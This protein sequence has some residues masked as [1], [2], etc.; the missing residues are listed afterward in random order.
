MIVDKIKNLNHNK[1]SGPD[2]MHS[3]LLKHYAKAFA[4]PLTLIITASLTNNQ[5]PIQYR[6]ANVTP[7]FKKSDE[8]LPSN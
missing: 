8:T 4:I 5:L 1:A 2:N 7:L 6:L 3:F